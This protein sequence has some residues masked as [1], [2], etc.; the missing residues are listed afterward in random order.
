MDLN[1]CRRKENESDFL[2]VRK[3]VNQ[4]TIT[5]YTL[6]HVLLL[7]K[8]SNGN[9]LYDRRNLNP[10]ISESDLAGK[11]GLLNTIEKRQ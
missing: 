11:L 8:G 1:K 6:P 5:S 2:N 4:K 10:R 9:W 3:L 7:H